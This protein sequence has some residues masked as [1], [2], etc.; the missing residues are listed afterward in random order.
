MQLITVES[1][2]ARVIEVHGRLD[3]AHAASFE[4]ELLPLLGA[5]TE[6][7]VAVVLDFA[8]VSYISSVGLRVL[9]LAAK[10]VRNQKGRIAICALTPIVAEIFQVSHFDMVLKLFPDV[11]AAVD[12]LRQ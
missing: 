9:M 1:D 12:A 2:S 8:G 10:Q 7:G 3:H 6:F 4:A 5:C 11:T